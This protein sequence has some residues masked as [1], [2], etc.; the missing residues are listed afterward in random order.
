MGARH[1]LR[2]IAVGLLLLIFAGSGWG[3][4]PTLTLETTLILV[5]ALVLSKKTNTVVGDLTREDF[6]LL[7]N[8][9][10]QEISY[11]S[12]EELPLSVVLLVDVS[13][14]VQP[15]IDEIQQAALDA[16]A[17]LKPEDKVALMI[18][19]SKPKLVAEL[20]TDRAVIADRLENIWSETADVGAATFINL[21]IYEAA[22]YL[23]KKTK[24]T[25]RRAIVMVTDDV[26]TSWWHGGPPRDVVLRELYEGGT[27]LCALVVGYARTVLKAINYGTTAAVTA[28]NPV[29]GAMLIAFR[30]LR[31]ISPITGSAKYYADRTGGV[32]VSSRH[33]EVGKIFIEV[34]ELL[35]TRYTLGY[36]PP[37]AS[38][39]R[40]R[41]IKLIVSH[42][43]KKE[44][45]D[46]RVI[47]RR[48]YFPRSGASR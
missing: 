29:A 3:Q 14:S 48:G 32:A 31:R 19:A 1:H 4:Q 43:A 25:E 2:R 7:D 42:R 17:K 15:I 33:E 10:E 38:D 13:G 34:I 26:D 45:G 35:R 30:L 44:K 28:A 6:V 12:R 24:P 46:L 11:F 39:R 20:T 36:F 8:G 22:R 27:T 47:A 5:D 9:K 18:F 23:R 21:G 40:F 41:E 37:P 16:L